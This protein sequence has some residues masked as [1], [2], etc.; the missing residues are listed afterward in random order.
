MKYITRSVKS[1]NVPNKD[2]MKYLSD[3]STFGPIESKLIT[4]IKLVRQTFKCD[5][6]TAKEHVFYFIGRESIFNDKIE[7]LCQGVGQTY[8]WSSSQS[9]HAMTFDNSCKFRENI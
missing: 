2:I 7:Y 3:L 6:K 1:D 4:A 9:Y 8:F 5:L